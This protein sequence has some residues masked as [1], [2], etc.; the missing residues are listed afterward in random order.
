MFDSLEKEDKYIQWLLRPTFLGNTFVSV[1]ERERERERMRKKMLVVV[2]EFISHWSLASLFL[3]LSACNF[4][5]M[6]PWI[7]V[8][9]EKNIK[10]FRVTS[11]ACAFD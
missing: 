10:L 8:A 6:V 9:A 5:E 3:R 11:P 7:P 1:R 4:D 2:V